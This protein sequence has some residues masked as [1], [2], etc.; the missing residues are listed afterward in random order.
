MKTF[1]ITTLMVIML[2]GSFGILT[3]QNVKE[4]VCLDNTEQFSIT[5]EYVKGEN[6]LIQVGLPI[7]YSSSHKSYPVLYVLDGDYA[8]GITKGIA[9]LLMIG[10][11]IK[12]II[13]IG[14]SYGKGVFAWSIK[15]T[16]DLTTSH[17][18]IFA[19]GQNTGGAD[20]FLKFVQYEL[21]PAVN[22]NYRTNPDSSA[23]CGESLGGLLNSYILWKQPELFKGYIIISPSLVW[24][25]KSVLKLESEYF[26]K[27]KELN[28]AVYIAYGSLDSK[29]VI[30]SPATELIQMIQM[31]N[32]KGLRLVKR[33]FEGET[34]MSVPSV[35]ITN[36][37]K[38]LFKP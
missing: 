2:S 4:K 35:A 16:R 15:R 23:I 30:I 19:K 3:A 9:D 33:V 29:E 8:F 1:Y 34:H 27:H 17:D 11:E 5:S 10:K 37:L 6:Y 28:K 20:N 36:G 25:N 13:V 21:F 38:T 18:T 31:H 24:N 32:Y 26:V 14:I 7:G 12:G 22:R